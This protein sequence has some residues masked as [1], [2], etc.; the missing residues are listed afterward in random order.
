MKLF[1]NFKKDFEAF[2]SKNLDKIEKNMEL[3]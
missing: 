2:A 1:V 3:R